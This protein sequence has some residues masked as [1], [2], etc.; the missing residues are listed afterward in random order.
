MRQQ[1]LEALVRRLAEA[2]Y[3]TGQA[4]APCQGYGCSLKRGLCVP[5]L[6]RLRLQEAREYNLFT[7]GLT[8][9]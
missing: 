9:E 2:L 3:C 5:C 7:Y 4:D 6:A 1:E 8:E